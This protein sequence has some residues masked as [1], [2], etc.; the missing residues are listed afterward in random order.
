[1]GVNANNIQFVS[2]TNFYGSGQMAYVDSGYVGGWGRYTLQ[3]STYQSTQAAGPFDFHQATTKFALNTDPDHTCKLTWASSIS[4]ANV[5]LV[6]SN[7]SQ[8]VA[9]SAGSLSLDSVF[10]GDQKNYRLIISRN[11][12]PT[13]AFDSTFAA[14]PPPNLSAFA[15]LQILPQG[16]L[17]AFGQGANDVI[18][19]NLPDFVKEDALSNYPNF[20][21]SP[22]LVASTSDDGQKAVYCAGGLPLLF[23]PLDF[24]QRAGYEA[25][26]L[27]PD[28]QSYVRVIPNSF[29]PMSNTGLQGLS[30]IFN[31]LPCAVVAD[32]T[33]N[34]LVLPNPAV[35]W[36]D[37]ANVDVPIVSED[38]QYFCIN[39]RDQSVGLVYKN[40]AGTWTLIGRVPPDK[41]YFRGH[42]TTELIT[43]GSTIQVFDVSS[44]PGSN[45]YFQAIRTFNYSGGQSPVT[46]IGYDIPSQSIFIETIDRHYYS[47]I[48]I[49]DVT[50]FSLSAK[51]VAYVPPAAPYP[52]KHIYSGNYHFLTSG[53]GEKIQP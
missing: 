36:K 25:Q 39:T 47:T 31:G 24:S 19:Y 45:A 42:S 2:S 34:T 4:D 30:T 13:Q 32:L 18:R 8:T 43:T 28:Q 3:V 38:G 15:G 26:I 21:G 27:T 1:M 7:T 29:S 33:V 20:F 17:L 50:N 44:S 35:V 11:T 37:S 48:R 49:Y 23:N 51:A 41:K 14:G 16:K 52:T 9:I 6:G 40:M 22:S 10:L 5:T 53:F 46:Q 12:H